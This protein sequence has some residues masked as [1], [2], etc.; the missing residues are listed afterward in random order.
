MIIPPSFT[1]TH[2]TKRFK[3]FLGLLKWSLFRG[4]NPFNGY[5]KVTFGIL[6]KLKHLCFFGY[7]DDVNT[8]KINGQR[9][10]TMACFN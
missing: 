8:K 1:K 10:R 4:T 5:N 2:F 3:Y 6:R 9:N 7:M